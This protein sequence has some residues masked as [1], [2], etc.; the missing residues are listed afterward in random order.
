MGPRENPQ[1]MFNLI[2]NKITKN[3]KMIL[4]QAKNKKIQPREAAMQIASKRVQK[5]MERKI[6][7]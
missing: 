7:S 3:L 1:Q 6:M 5:A 4:D 2:E